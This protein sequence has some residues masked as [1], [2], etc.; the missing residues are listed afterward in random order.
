MITFPPHL[1]KIFTRTPYTD[2][3]IKRCF[4]ENERPSSIISIRLTEIPQISDTSGR[5]NSFLLRKNFK[6][7]PISRLIQKNPIFNFLF[8]NHN[9]HSFNLLKTKP[10]SQN[11]K[12]AELQNCYHTVAVIQHITGTPPKTAE[13]F[14]GMM[15]CRHHRRPLA[16]N[17]HDKRTNS[18]LQAIKKQPGIIPGC[19]L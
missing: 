5:L 16:G 19:F 12:Q 7:T 13:S 17:I 4:K 10:A 2:A 6:R 14:H 15:F 11:A 3:N 9:F 18:K 8:R 1:I